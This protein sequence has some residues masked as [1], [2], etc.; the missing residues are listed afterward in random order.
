MGAGCPQT[1][2]CTTLLIRCGSYPLQTKKTSLIIYC[3]KFT[4]SSF[5]LKIVLST[6][7]FND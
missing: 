2:I 3:F 7:I 1:L 4:L 6:Y 5:F